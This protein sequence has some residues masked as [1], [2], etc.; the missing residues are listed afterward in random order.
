MRFLPIFALLMCIQPASSAIESANALATADRMLR[1][2]GAQNEG[3]GHNHGNQE[4]NERGYEFG[5][6]WLMDTMCVLGTFAGA[7]CF[8]TCITRQAR[9]WYQF[10]K[11]LS[12][13][14]EEKQ[15]K[16]K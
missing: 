5:S 14:R 4:K 10:S 13:A 16:I 2:E 1:G 7:C 9:S 3:S 15:K 8:F 12:A 11:S 6:N